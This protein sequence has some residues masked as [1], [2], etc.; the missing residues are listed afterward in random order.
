MAVRFDLKIWG[1]LYF[2]GSEIIRNLLLWLLIQEG[3]QFCILEVFLVNFIRTGEGRRG[4]VMEKLK[5]GDRSIRTSTFPLSSRSRSKSSLTRG[6]LA[7]RGSSLPHT[8]REI[9]VSRERQRT[10]IDA[11]DSTERRFVFLSVTKPRGR[12][13]SN[14]NNFSNPFSFREILFIFAPILSSHVVI[15]ACNW[16]L[17]KF[18]RKIS[19]PSSRCFVKK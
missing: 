11:A 18:W 15:I 4:R 7:S 12:R 5:K 3:D 2:D 13:L 14:F 17:R 10:A 16:I 9:Y 6:G 1:A 8:T 19:F